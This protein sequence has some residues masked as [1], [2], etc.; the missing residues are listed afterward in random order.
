M[1]NESF[2]NFDCF[3]LNKK[4]LYEIQKVGMKQRKLQEEAEI[5]LIS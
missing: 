5:F 2:D 1:K 4:T 3:H